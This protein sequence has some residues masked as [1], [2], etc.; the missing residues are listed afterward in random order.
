L[1]AQASADK[2]TAEQ[3]AKLLELVSQNSSV[4]PQHVAHQRKNADRKSVASAEADMR[5]AAIR[6][7]KDKAEAAARAEAEEK[8]RKAQEAALVFQQRVA[9]I[10]Q[11]FLDSQ[12][13]EAASKKGGGRKGRRT[14]A[15]D[16]SELSS[17]QLAVIAKGRRAGDE[18]DDLEDPLDAVEE[19]RRA[20]EVATADLFADEPTRASDAA[21]SAA[22]PGVAPFDVEGLFAGLPALPTVE[23]DAP[24]RDGYAAARSEAAE[25]IAEQLG[26]GGA[27]GADDDADV[28]AEL[29]AEDS[30]DYGVADARDDEPGFE[31]ARVDPSERDLRS[32]YASAV[33]D[34][35]DDD[36]E[37]LGVMEPIAQP[38][39]A[40]KSSKQA[41][42]RKRR[43]LR[44]TGGSDED[45][46]AGGKDAQVSSALF[47]SESEDESGL[48]A[49]A[50]QPAA[51]AAAAS[52]EEEDNQEKEEG[53]GL[54]SSDLAELSAALE[55][56][57]SPSEARL[58]KRNRATAGG[59][60]SKR[61]KE[62]AD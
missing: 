29:E 20:F 36:E 16:E 14:N 3:V 60:D 54:T 7:A 58:D 1:R 59:A 41:K 2:L 52:G 27:D 39:A 24:V 19:L 18:D 30:D 15:M 47:D 46:D 45:S 5:R 44:A 35:D 17:Q 51:A 25:R 40:S 10:N 13:K 61:V 57:S 8:L 56:G 6:E 22:V 50:P 48:P 32:K 21:R 42:G 53:E 23:A 11:T 62:T 38:A 26:L 31:A 55:G 34:D 37:G 28:L 9:I 33:D 4:A 12:A 49:P 43:L